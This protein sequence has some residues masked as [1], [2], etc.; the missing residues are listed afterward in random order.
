MAELKQAGQQMSSIS[1]EI[2]QE[3]PKSEAGSGLLTRPQSK[4]VM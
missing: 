3:L 2:K 1:E 4:E